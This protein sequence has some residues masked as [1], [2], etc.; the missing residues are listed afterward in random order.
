[1]YDLLI[2]NGTFVTVDAEGTIYPNGLL[3][4][5]G[6]QIV[7]ISQHREGTPL[8]PSVETVDAGGGIVLPGL[9]NAHTHLPMVLFRGLADDLPLMSWLNEHI[10]PA[11][12]ALITPP[13]VRAAVRLACAE[14][15][16]AGVTT[17]CDGYFLEDTVAEV[18]AEM[19]LRA[20]LGQGV[21]DAPAPGV[22]DPNRNVAV[23]E[24][25]V[26]RW[27][28]CSPLIRPSVFCHASYTCG[29]ETLQAAKALARAAG[30]LFQIHVA[31]T[32]D[33]VGLIRE[34]YGCS[35]VAHLERLGLLDHET[36]MVHGVWLDD[37]D[38]ALAAD[39][40][41]GIVHCPESNMKLGAGIAPVTQFLAAGLRVGLGTDGC[42]SNNNQDLFK[43]MDTAAKLH[44]VACGDPTV[45]SAAET[46][47]MATIDGARAIGMDM[48]IGSLEVGK[49]ADI[50]ILDGRHPRLHPLHNPV[51]QAVYA[52]AGDCVRDTIVAGRFLVRNRQLIGWEL[53]SI[54]APLE[55][56]AQT[57]R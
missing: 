44:K 49:Q 18:V 51:S 19:G 38:I 34:R 23:A 22:T 4:V 28:D 39:R 1:M 50:T 6:D 7:A 29:P 45:V 33:E 13:N 47:R 14:L 57:L 9:V 53:A 54:L 15:L 11:E 43:E 35:P 24:A 12:A 26:Q 8:P 56:A 3:A 17:C 42:A 55:K 36:L 25:F 32:R 52:A 46:L 27:Q 20:V 5:I 30:V 41:V 48:A 21:I 37:T 16:L 31:E 10:F 40:G 2:H